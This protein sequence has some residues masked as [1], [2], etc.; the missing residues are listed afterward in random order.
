MTVDPPPR[1]VE[2]PAEG[3]DF[4]LPDLPNVDESAIR[5]AVV[6][7]VFR[8]GLAAV[9]WLLV[10]MLLWTMIAFGV[11]ALR[12]DTFRIVRDG[13]AVAHPEY[14]IA[15]DGS[16]CSDGLTSPGTSTLTVRLRPRATVGATIEGS[17][18]VHRGLT[19]GLTIDLGRPEATPI[20]EALSRG[21]PEK[22]A[23]AAFLAS[24][25]T[26]VT[27]SAIVEFAKPVDGAKLDARSGPY[28]IDAIFL[29]SI[30]PGPG[31]LGTVSWPSPRA[32]DFRAWAWGLSADDDTDLRTLGLP[33]AA[34]LRAAANRDRIFGYVLGSASVADLQ[35]LLS[36][37][38]VRSVNV[39]DVGFDPARQSQP[40]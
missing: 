28:P 29:G 21:R 37:P 16:C 11:E 13:I 5:R 4:E 39:T 6:R 40:D 17:G 19:G 36:D 33:S 14:E 38:Q 32:D 23:T 8:T 15:Q 25:P 31:Y 22:R 26:S 18:S 7:G 2:E 3:T 9:S 34:D 24:L 35:A 30:Y 20:G 1:G 12:G 10:L 27:A